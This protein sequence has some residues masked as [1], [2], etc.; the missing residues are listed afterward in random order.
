MSQNYVLETNKFFDLA[1]KSIEACR[2]GVR[3]VSLHYACALACTRSGSAA[4]CQQIDEN[5]FYGCETCCNMLFSELPRTSS[6]VNLIGS[7]DLIL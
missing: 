4:V 2:A 7:T 5:I 1:F 6:D 3:L